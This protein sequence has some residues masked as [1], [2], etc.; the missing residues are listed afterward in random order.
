MTSAAPSPSRFDNP[1]MKSAVGALQVLFTTF[2][3]WIGGNI[4]TS[5][6]DFSNKLDGVVASIAT[7][8]LEQ[9]MQ[10]RDVQEYAKQ[11]AQVQT[12]L[13]T[14]EKRVDRMGYVVDQIEQGRPKGGR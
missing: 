5:I 9:Q 2:L 7:V 11:L 13:T 14:L 8:T 4:A 10:K 6:K 3:C 1:L 12:T